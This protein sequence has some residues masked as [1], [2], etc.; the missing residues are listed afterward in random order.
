MVAVEVTARLIVA[1]LLA[2]LQAGH[3]PDE[4]DGLAVT[5]PVLALTPGTRG[6][7]AQPQH[8]CEQKYYCQ[9]CWIVACEIVWSD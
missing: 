5:L 6:A 2:V 9:H 7:T 3:L 4:V 1:P 8:Y